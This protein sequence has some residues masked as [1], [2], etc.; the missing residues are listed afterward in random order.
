MNI[1]RQPRILLVDDDP[2]ALELTLD[3]IRRLGLGYEARVACGGFE[4]LDYLLGRGRFHERRRHPLPDIIVMNLNM[5]PLDGAAVLKRMQSVDFLRDIP[6][7]ALCLSEQ[8]LARAKQDQVRAH[9][10][11]VKPLSPSIFRDLLTQ[12][13]P[14]VPNVMP[15]SA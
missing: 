2:G 8:Q 14:L 3:A 12:F 1:K 11:V 15:I 6:V 10:F 9:A 7:V 13:A 5:A 4:A